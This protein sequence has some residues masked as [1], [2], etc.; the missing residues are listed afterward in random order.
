MNNR[1]MCLNTDICDMPKKLE[2]VFFQY[3]SF[4]HA[5][6]QKISVEGAGFVS[7][8]PGALKQSIHKAA[9]I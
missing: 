6:M 7:E 1:T 9:V 3:L 8:S 5:V 4:A 2:T